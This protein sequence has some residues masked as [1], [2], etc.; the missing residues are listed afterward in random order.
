MAET[1]IT[2][3]ATDTLKKTAK[4]LENGSNEIES[5]YKAA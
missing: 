1:K 3:D 4:T 2:T 5:L